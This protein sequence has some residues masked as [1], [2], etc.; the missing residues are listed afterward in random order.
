MT[1]RRGR[2][3]ERWSDDGTEHII[4]YTDKTVVEGAKEAGKGM[5]KGSAGTYLTAKKGAKVTVHYTEKGTEK[6]AGGVKDA[7]D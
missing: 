1:R 6:T 5:E 4:K 7:V 3:A 2:G